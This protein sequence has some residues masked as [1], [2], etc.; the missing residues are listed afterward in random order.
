MTRNKV[1]KVNEAATI[2]RNVQTVFEAHTTEPRLIQPSD[3]VNKSH[4]FG[5]KPSNL[6]KTEQ[7]PEGRKTA[8]VKLRSELAVKNKETLRLAL[9]KA[10][11]T[12]HH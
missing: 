12:M 11:I 1:E 2:A 6:V 3:S 9:D 5:R 4:G 7:I 10:K 8:Q